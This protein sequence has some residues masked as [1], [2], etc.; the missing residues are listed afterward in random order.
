M[1]TLAD[2]L[3]HAGA[4]MTPRGDRIIAAHFGSVSGELSVCRKHAGLAVRT[5]LDVLELGA[6]AERLELA[7]ARLLGG[8]ALPPGGAARIGSAWCAHAEPDR[9]LVVGPPGAVASVRRL[10]AGAALALRSREPEL[11]PIELVGPRVRGV[12][13]R[14]G[15]PA[16]L[17][18]QAVRR[19]WWRDGTVV[20]LCEDRDRLLLLVPASDAGAAWHEL[21]AA[22]RPLELS[23]VGLDALARLAAAPA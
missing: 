1:A 7:L 9:A 16:D 6:R 8:A 23:C 18:P 4:V 21:L 5:D 13:A 2:D 10:T 11:T 17:A 14:A 12:L 22:G 20:L 19:C 15:L 3:C